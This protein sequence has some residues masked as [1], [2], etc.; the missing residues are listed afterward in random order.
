MYLYIHI[1]NIIKPYITNIP[2]Q[3]MG[4]PIWDIILCIYFNQ[5]DFRHP[6]WFCWWNLSPVCHRQLHCCCF[7]P[8]NNDF[9]LVKLLILKFLLVESHVVPGSKNSLMRFQWFVGKIPTN[10]SSIGCDTAMDQY[11]QKIHQKSDFRRMNI[12]RHAPAHTDWV[13]ISGTCLAPGG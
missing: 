1:Y 7:S 5:V 4:P 3:D 8:K 9:L 10:P 6:V 13:F 12:K 2:N 11:P